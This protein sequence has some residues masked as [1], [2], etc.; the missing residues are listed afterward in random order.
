M[1]SANDLAQALEQ[2]RPGVDLLDFVAEFMELD[3]DRLSY[4][5]EDNV[6]QISGLEERGPFSLPTQLTGEMIDI[7]IR[8]LSD[9]DGPES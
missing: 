9:E 3:R 5:A 1:N 2:A 6:V 4:H 8:N 7:M